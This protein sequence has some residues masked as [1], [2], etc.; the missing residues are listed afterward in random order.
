[1]TKIEQLIQ[2]ATALSDEQ[3]DALIVHA[4]SLADEPLFYSVPADVRASIEQGHAEHRAKSTNPA[5]EVFDRLHGRGS[6]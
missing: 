3:L 5:A 4:R 2:A 6:T 1:M